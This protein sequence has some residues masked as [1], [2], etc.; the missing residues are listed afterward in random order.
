[1]HIY[2]SETGLY[3]AEARYFDPRLGRFLTR[4]Y[5]LGNADNPPSLHRYAYGLSLR[6]WQSSGKDNRRIRTTSVIFLLPAE[7]GL[8]H[9]LDE[10]PDGV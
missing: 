8:V 6:R 5:F 4:D 3:N 1:M 9:L 2:D 10:A 7:A